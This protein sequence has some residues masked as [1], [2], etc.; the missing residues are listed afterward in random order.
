[1]EELS[2]TNLRDYGLWVDPDLDLPAP[3]NVPEE[4]DNPVEEDNPE[5]GP[6]TAPG[7]SIVIF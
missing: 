2:T 3:P 1:M 7:I 4:Q 5:L 6:W